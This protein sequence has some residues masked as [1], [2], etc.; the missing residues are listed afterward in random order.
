MFLDVPAGAYY[1]DAITWAVSKAVARGTE[2]DHFSPDAPCTRAEAVT[3]LWRAM[4]SPI[5]GGDMP[6]HDVEA[7]AFYYYAVLWAQSRGIVNGTNTGHFSPDALCTRAEAVTFLHR[8]YGLPY[9]GESRFSDVDRTAWYAPAVAWAASSEITHG[10]DTNAF[11]PNAVCTRG[12]V[13]TFL[14]RAFA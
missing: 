3:F 7:G 12:Q 4:G 6:F 10:T 8:A 9:G 5:L 13:I 11:Q 1:S 2:R 14:Y